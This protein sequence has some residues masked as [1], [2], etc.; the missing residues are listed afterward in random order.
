[1]PRPPI[2]PAATTVAEISAV[3]VDS[4]D[5]GPAVL[6]R[7]PCSRQLRGTARLGETP[8]L[9]ATRKGVAVEAPTVTLHHPGAA[10]EAPTVALRHPGVALEAP[11][12]APRPS[13]VAVEAAI[14]ALRHPE[15]VHL[16]AEAVAVEAA[17]PV[18]AV[19]RLTAAPTAE[20][21]AARAKPDASHLRNDLPS[22]R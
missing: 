6:A 22:A 9:I 7:L 11:T 4:A 3:S 1:M 10:L 13:G 16:A 17:H 14:A 15:A 18:A 5:R 19:V 20:D 2:S 21:A 12:A 8:V